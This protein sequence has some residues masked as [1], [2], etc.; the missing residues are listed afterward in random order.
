M[1]RR[2]FFKVTAGV[3][4][5][6][7]AGGLLDVHPSE[8]ELPDPDYDHIVTSAFPVEG[9][10]NKTL[11]QSYWHFSFPPEGGQLKIPGY[12]NIKALS[13]TGVDDEGCRVRIMPSGIPYPQGAP[14]WEFMS[15]GQPDTLFFEPVWF[16]CTDAVIKV[17]GAALLQICLNH[18]GEAPMQLALA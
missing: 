10:E 1:K 15:P 5:S 7:T 9:T 4:V 18:Y 16:Q 12:S 17:E 6:A 2:E 8:P 3:V 13:A 14:E 11:T